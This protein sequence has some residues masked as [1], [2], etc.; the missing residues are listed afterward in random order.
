MNRISPDPQ[1][2]KV[3]SEDDWWTLRWINLGRGGKIQVDDL[4]QYKTRKKDVEGLIQKAL[5]FERDQ[6]FHVNDAGSALS[7][8]TQNPRDTDTLLES[9]SR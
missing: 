4:N 6:S 7:K 9:N 2:L 8:L 3:V 5:M 1:A